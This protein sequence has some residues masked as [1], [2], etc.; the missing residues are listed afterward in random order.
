MITKILSEGFKGLSFAQDLKQF[1][2]FCGKN[3]VG[4]SARTEALA[5]AVMGYNPRD[6]KKRPGD[7]V[8]THGA[9]DEFVVGFVIE[10]D[11]IAQT[12]SRRFKKTD[13]GGTMDCYCNKTPQ[14]ASQVEA[15]LFKIGNPR[16]FDLAAFNALS[17]AGKIGRLFELFPPSIDVAELEEKILK[18]DELESRLNADLKAI[19]STI[20]RLTKERSE[21]DVSG[22]VA[23]LQADIKAKETA[24]EEAQGQLKEIEAEARQKSLFDEQKRQAEAKAKADA[25]EA[26]RKAQAAQDAAIQRE[27]E[28]MEAEKQQIQKQ[29]AIDRQKAIEE[30]IKKERAEKAEKYIEVAKQINSPV[31]V[32]EPCDCSEFVAGLEKIKATMER[33]GCQSCAASIVLKALIA[34]YRRKE[35]VGC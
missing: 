29:H 19:K 30:A 4:K 20:E 5:I 28:R 1:N 17:D 3:G 25:E 14:K 34:K 2:L 10:T 21:I 22:T 26:V 31:A 6:Q 24:L 13:K 33:A 16:V 35:A 23:E 15:T 27:R 12:F 7:I 11:N 9:G 18:A 32:P 8:A